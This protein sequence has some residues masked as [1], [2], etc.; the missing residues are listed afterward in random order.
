MALVSPF[1]HFE[2]A[3]E[4]ALE[5]IEM[6]AC[7]MLIRVASLNAI[8]SEI[9]VIAENLRYTVDVLIAWHEKR[10]DPSEEPGATE[11]HPVVEHEVDAG[12]AAEMT[13]EPAIGAKGIVV[14]T[15]YGKR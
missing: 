3:D 11:L 5:W 15:C 14:A 10:F 4:R 1:A 9:H 6:G 7:C 2:A 13:V 12:R 8:P